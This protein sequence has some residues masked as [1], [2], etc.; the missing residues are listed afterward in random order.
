MAG[1]AG[2]VPSADDLSG[3]ESSRRTGAARQAAGPVAGERPHHR[4]RERHRAPARSRVCSTR[5]QKGTRHC[6][7]R[8]WG[9]EA[10]EDPGSGGAPTCCRC[11][12]ARPGSE[13]RRPP[14][15]SAPPA[16]AELVGFTLYISRAP[17]CLFPQVG[18]LSAPLGSVAGWLLTPTPKVRRPTLL[19]HSSLPKEDVCFPLSLPLSAATLVSAGCVRSCV[20]LGAAC[21]LAL[22]VFLGSPLP[23]PD[24]GDCSSG[25]T[26]R[27]D[28]WFEF[29]KGGAVW[30]V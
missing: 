21:E 9:L 29:E 15:L 7:S 4:R 16:R 12:D 5:R 17:D 23:S 22:R 14:H 13:S 20:E 3:G 30:L 2:G 19:P 18:S 25:G 11:R 6:A 8:G 1:R 28:P 24:L 10:R 26:K 27:G